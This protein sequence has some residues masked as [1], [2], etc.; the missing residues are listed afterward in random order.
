MAGTAPTEAAK[1]SGAA[2]PAGI[3]Q[4]TTTGPNATHDPPD[5]GCTRVAFE[6]VLGAKAPNRK[7]VND[8]RSRLMK[9][10]SS[11]DPDVYDDI[12]HRLIE[13]Y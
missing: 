5:T 7:A 9:C 12:Y 10:R 3:A 2:S 11:M 6:S 4:G 1:P 13:R 8:A